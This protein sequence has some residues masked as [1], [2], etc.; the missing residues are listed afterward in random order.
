MVLDSV[1]QRL[2]HHRKLV[3]ADPT[4][5]KVIDFQFAIGRCLIHEKEFYAIVSEDVIDP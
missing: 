5:M 4:F 1:G 3:Q 2:F